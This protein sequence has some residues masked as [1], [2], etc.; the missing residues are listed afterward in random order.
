M[1]KNHHHCSRTSMLLCG[2]AALIVGGW[3]EAE[4]AAWVV[5]AGH[6]RQLDLTSGE[7]GLAHRLE[8][9]GTVRALARHPGGNLY[10]LTETCCPARQRFFAIDPATGTARPAGQLAKPRAWLGS[11][12]I[13]E[14]GRLWL[15]A[16]GELWSIDPAS[17]LERRAASPDHGR[18][19]L[20]AAATPQGLYGITGSLASFGEP[21]VPVA[22]P[23]LV[24]ID[25]EQG[26]LHT[27]RGLPPSESGFVGLAADQVGGFWFLAVDRSISASPPAVRHTFWRFEPRTGGLVSS[28]E[29]VGNEIDLHFQAFALTDAP[30]AKA[31]GA[32][33]LDTLGLMALGVVLALAAQYVTARRRHHPPGRPARLQGR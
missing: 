13:D 23:R 25:V 10:A 8:I 1:L 22:D 11:L 14:S 7:F 18:I 17:G 27:V 24:R 20:T 3:A 4:P 31:S 26:R 12:T 6:L 19:L 16:D 32:P 15:T 29:I 21:S 5:S 33:T 2:L 30:T 9:P 28:A